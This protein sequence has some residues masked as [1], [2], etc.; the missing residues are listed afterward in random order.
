MRVSKRVLNDFSNGLTASTPCRA[1][2]RLD[3]LPA[4]ECMGFQPGAGRTPDGR[5][6]FPTINGLVAVDPSLIRLNTQ[7][8][9]VVIE[10]VLIDGQLAHAS[11]L[12]ARL[13]AEVIVPAGRE[14]L[15]IQYTSLNLAAPDRARFNYRLKGHESDWTEAGSTRIA[16]YS[17]LPPGGYQFEVIA[18]NED[19]VWNEAG[20]SISITVV[21]PF[22]LTWW[23]LGA[24]FMGFLGMTVGSVHYAS[25]QRWRRQVERLH[26]KELVERERARIARD[27]HDKL[28]A[29]MTQVALLGE[30][31]ESDKDFPDEVEAHARQISQTA[32]ETTL[33]LD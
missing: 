25:T 32:R 23:F 16:R 7:P 19:G 30:L 2:S 29:S 18:S 24:C 28:G 3:G 20:R 1:Y 22:W 17:K 33:V 4:L 8:P 31:V 27:I 6:W 5:L 15:E 14:R 26:Q 13:P 12:L 9:P 10:R 11:G 21:P